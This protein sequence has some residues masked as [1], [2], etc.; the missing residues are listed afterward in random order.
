M[1][2][3]QKSVNPSPQPQFPSTPRRVPIEFLQHLGW[4]AEVG[5]IPVRVFPTSQPGRD[6]SRLTGYKRAPSRTPLRHFLVPME[7]ECAAGEKKA[8]RRHLIGRA[9]A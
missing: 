1:T 4:L 5:D 8:A 3:T 2:P 9:N 6:N 7:Q